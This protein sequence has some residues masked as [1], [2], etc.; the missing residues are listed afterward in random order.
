M[1][2]T[3]TPSVVLRKKDFIDRVVEKSGLKKKDVRPAVD[4]VLAAMAD[5]LAAGEDLVLPPLGKL[6]VARVKDL[7]NGKLLSI[8]LRVMDVVSQETSD[9]PLAENEE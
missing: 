9:E 8:K 7:P 1:N 5:S 4:A 3:S 6:K 2:D